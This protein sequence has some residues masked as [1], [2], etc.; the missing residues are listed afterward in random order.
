[1]HRSTRRACGALAT[2]A[3]LAAPASAH[4][5]TITTTADAGLTGEVQGLLST[6]AP[7]LEPL[8]AADGPSE[9]STDSA[10]STAAADDVFAPWNDPADYKLVSGGDFESGATGWKL[11]SGA[12]L[13]DGGSPYATTGAASRKA[14]LLPAGARVTSPLT[15]I[16][17]GSPVARMFART[18][19]GSGASLHV[20]VLD[21]A[22]EAKSV[23]NL[24]EVAS[25]D[26]TRRFSTSQGRLKADEDGVA[27][28][29]LRFT[30]GSGATWQVDD[31][32]V[33]PRSLR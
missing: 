13:V 22:G 25:W 26:A 10:C 7:D 8:A 1:M 27:K 28:M 15:C 29:R 31:V 14:L 11:E 16:T 5:L 4:A 12:K 24:P 19:S 20:E 32:Y 2:L 18:V 3:A 23:G 17:P 6:W 9:T 33:D 21:E 30:A